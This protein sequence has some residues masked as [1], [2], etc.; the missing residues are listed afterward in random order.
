MLELALSYNMELG[1]G[2]S[3]SKRDGYREQYFLIARL[4]LECALLL[5]PA[6]VGPNEGLA[7]SSPCASSNFSCFVRDSIREKIVE[8]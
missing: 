7:N 4:L 1:H 3:E 6:S 8:Y 5:L 2:I